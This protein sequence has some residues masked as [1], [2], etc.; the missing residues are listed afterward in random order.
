MYDLHGWYEIEMLQTETHKTRDSDNIV[1]NL[2][3][4]AQTQCVISVVGTQVN[5][6]AVISEMSI[7]DALT[8]GSASTATH[9]DI[10]QMQ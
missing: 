1:R 5:D 8:S 6:G 7:A 2:V 10:T 4:Q 3:N 9:F